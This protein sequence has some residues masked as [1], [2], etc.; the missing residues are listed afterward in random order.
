[1]RLKKLP[2]HKSIFLSR[3]QVNQKP[4]VLLKN[5]FDLKGKTV[6]YPQSFYK[7]YTVSLA[8]IFF[9]PVWKTVVQLVLL[10]LSYLSPGCKQLC[11][12]IRRCSG[13][14]GIFA[15]PCWLTSPLKLVSPQW[16]S[17]NCCI[18]I[19]N[20]KAEINRQKMT[21]NCLTSE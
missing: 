16:L 3:N 9:F 11:G 7:L 21:V 5:P 4:Q 13:K 1:M 19:T 12:K 10:L 8:E 2:I 15:S 20:N 14:Q 6:P 18:Y 17:T